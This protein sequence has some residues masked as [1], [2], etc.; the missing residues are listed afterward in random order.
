VLSPSTATWDPR[1]LFI[2][3]GRGNSAVEF[4]RHWQP[5][6]DDGWTLIVPQSSQVYDSESWCWDDAELAR[7]EVRQHWEDCRRKRGMDLAGMIV[8]GASQGGVLAMEA[9]NEAGV[10]WLSVIPSFPR[11][12]DVSPL[13]AVPS[14][15]V[16]AILLG[17]ND[18][19]AARARTVI[20][21]L[22]AGGVRVIVKTMQGAGHELPPDFCDFAAEALR[23]LLAYG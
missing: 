13:M 7:A 17:E 6:L 1:S 12:Y 3:H 10:P 18:P 5:L 8:A 15:T 20:S 21:Q 19:A 9:A 11:G 2:I 16:G 4:S 14:H 22:D 23:G